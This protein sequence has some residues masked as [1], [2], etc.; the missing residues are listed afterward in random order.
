M[1]TKSSCYLVAATAAALSTSTAGV[2]AAAYMSGTVECLPESPTI[3]VG[4][5]FFTSPSPA[6]ACNDPT[7]PDNCISSN[8]GG[9]SWEYNFVKG[10]ENGTSTF[11]LEQNVIDKA[12]T[13]LVVTV[14]IDDDSA[15]TIDV[16]NNDTCAACSDVNCGG[17]ATAISF[18]CTN[19]E[20]GRAS[21]GCEPLEKILYPLMIDDTTDSMLKE[22]TESSVDGIDIGAD[23]SSSSSS[24]SSPFS[25]FS[26]VAMSVVGFGTLANFFL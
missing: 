11:D 4:S 5:A 2:E 1:N 9:Y 19:V 3:C 17:D 10:L 25:S 23:T 20:N 14:K 12:E 13:G 22:N 24:L 26:S 18:D 8:V 15:C 6:V 21:K 16:G 7:D